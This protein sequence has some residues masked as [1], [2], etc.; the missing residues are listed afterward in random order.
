LKWVAVY[1]V[2]DLRRSVEI[3]GKLSAESVKQ[4]RVIEQAEEIIC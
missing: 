4:L 1:M 2:F 3:T